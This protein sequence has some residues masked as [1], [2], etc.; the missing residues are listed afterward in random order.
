MANEN[1]AVLGKNGR[2]RL[3][4]RGFLR[5]A[6]GLALA[7]AA[8]AA[9]AGCGGGGGDD[10]NNDDNGNNYGRYVGTYRYRDTG[11]N[12]QVAVSFTVDENLQLTYW[13]LYTDPDSP[14]ADFGQTTVDSNGNFSLSTDGV[15]T[16]GQIRNNVV[17]GRTRLD[18]GDFTFNFRAPI[19]GQ[20]VS[21][22]P[23]DFLVGSFEGFNQISGVDYTTILGVSPDGNAT[24]FG[25]F[26]D[27]DTSEVDYY[28][29]EGLS[30]SR[31]GDVPS[32]DL[33]FLNLYDDRIA[34]SDGENSDVRLNFRFG[35]S[36]PDISIN[37]GDNVDLTL[38]PIDI[39]RAQKN[40]KTGK[41]RAVPVRRGAPALK[42]VVRALKASRAAVASPVGR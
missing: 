31:N 14:F 23:R 9:L 3:T 37:S 24:F 28:Y 40:G 17:E 27:P 6:S 32:A 12:G 1:E 4:R 41:T 22:T 36:A 15:T 11:D 19:V 10:D 7:V 34:L 29:F 38:T 2:A 8:S 5:G 25:A 26:D 42:L 20:L 33:Y 39:G 21:T 16:S 18:N 35:E 30:F 13:T